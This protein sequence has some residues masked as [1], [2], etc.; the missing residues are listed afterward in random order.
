MAVPRPHSRGFTL[1][2][3]A[4]TIA[5]IALVM[6]VA[7]TTFSGVSVGEMRA[8]TARLASMSRATYDEAAL[9]GKIHRLAIEFQKTNAGGEV[10]A[11]ATIT[12]EATEELLQ[13]SEGKGILARATPKGGALAGWTALASGFALD[14]DGDTGSLTPESLLPDGVDGLL[15]LR[16][17]GGDDDD[18]ETSPVDSAFTAVAKSYA[19]HSGLQILDVWTEGMEEPIREGRAYIYFFPHGS[20]QDALIHVG[21]ADS[22]RSDAGFTVKVEA[23]TGRTTVSNEYLEMPK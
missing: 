12:V 18:E 11:P 10:E 15:G 4:V 20:A 3:M 13:F 23:L 19:F 22:G 21:F 16:S 1:A 2:E 17:S 5:V 6:G 9:T 8:A 14:D 7:I